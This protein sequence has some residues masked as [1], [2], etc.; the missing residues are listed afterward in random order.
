MSVEDPKKNPRGGQP[1]SRLKALQ[2]PAPPAPP[3]AVALSELLSSRAQTPGLEEA[4]KQFSVPE[5]LTLFDEG[6]T[7]ALAAESRDDNTKALD[8]EAMARITGGEPA[9]QPAAYQPPPYKVE[10]DDTRQVDATSMSRLIEA[11]MRDEGGLAEVLAASLRKGQSMEEVLIAAAQ[12]EPT[13]SRP[14]LSKAPDRQGRPA[15]SAPA[16]APPPP[17]PPARSAPAR[18]ES[19]RVDVR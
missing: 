3:P 8:D 2:P 17:T 1:Q 15:A 12:L 10:R 19:V 6:T 7:S 4:T 13:K 14:P 11:S 16:P 18:V 9:Q 5:S